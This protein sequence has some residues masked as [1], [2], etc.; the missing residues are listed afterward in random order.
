MSRLS[1]KLH[2]ERRGFTLDVAF[3]VPAEGV[4][5]LFGASGAGKS[6]VLDCLAGIQRVPRGQIQ[7][8]EREWQGEGKR[9]TPPE[10]R[11]VGYV[12]QESALFPHL[13]V[14]QNLEYGLR[15]LAPERR[16]F[17]TGQV[18]EWMGIADLLRSQP[19]E[20]SG[21][22][23]QRVA[24]GR[25]LLAHPC[26]VLLD[27]P[28]AALDAD[29]RADVLEHLARVR[30]E[31]DVP[32]MYV[33]HSLDEVARL[34]E[35]IILLDDGRVTAAGPIDDVLS[36]LDVGQHLRE[37][38]GV[39]V[40]GRVIDHDDRYHLSTVEASLGR[41]LVHRVQVHRGGEVRI[42][43]RA[44]DVSVTMD[45]QPRSSILNVVPVRIVEIAQTEPGQALVRMAPHDG[46]GAL[47][48][49]IT[50]RSAERLGLHEGQPVFAQVKSVSLSA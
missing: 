22:Q 16:V 29:A 35:Q 18:A 14:Q 33:S 36:R 24:L 49:R 21:G 39:V 30:S 48:A 13:T 27:E 26:L 12:P 25:A 41:F 45:A 10:Q 47:L 40:T 37:E 15:R 28:V 44:R 31:M 7:F 1:V 11:G 4:T 19:A 32:V 23:R 20:L 50:T 8:G 17:D 6:T 5:S 3:D 34:S 42:R 9:F 38:A 46:I 2:L 43:I